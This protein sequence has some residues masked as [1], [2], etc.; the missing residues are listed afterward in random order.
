MAKDINKEEFSEE[1][2]LKLEM[3]F[4]LTTYNP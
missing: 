4:C 1:T 2:K 3:H